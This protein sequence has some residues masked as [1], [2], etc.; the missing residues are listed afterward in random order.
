[1]TQ[2]QGGGGLSR[3]QDAGGVSGSQRR[4]QTELRDGRAWPPL[5]MDRPRSLSETRVPAGEGVQ[6][7][8]F[9]YGNSRQGPGKHIS[10]LQVG[11][12]E[13]GK[14]LAT[15]T[16]GRTSVRVPAPGRV[17]PRQG[18]SQGQ[19]SGWPQNTGAQSVHGGPIPSTGE[20][21]DWTLR[22]H[23]QAGLGVAVLLL[24]VTRA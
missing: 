13:E 17:A 15:P 9:P 1:M 23:S 7:V 19:S 10:G 14:G 8:S 12:R 4:R 16:Q 6:P 5:W 18:R 11:D 21:E 3:G 2:C 22:G 20:S 24:R